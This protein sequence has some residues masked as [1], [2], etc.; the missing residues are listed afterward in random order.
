MLGGGCFAKLGVKYSSL[1]SNSVGSGGGEMLVFIMCNDDLTVLS[2]VS[3]MIL[4]YI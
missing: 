4:V 1:G 3:S 2:L